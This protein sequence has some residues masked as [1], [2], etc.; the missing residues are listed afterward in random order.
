MKKVQQAKTNH[1]TNLRRSTCL[2]FK[3]WKT[4]KITLTIESNLLEKLALPIH[5]PSSLLINAML[6]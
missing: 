1:G 2:Y 4:L 3:H 5:P 6:I